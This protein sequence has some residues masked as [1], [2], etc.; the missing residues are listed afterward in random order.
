MLLDC[1]WPYPY[2]N[3][4]CDGGDVFGLYLFLHRVG[5]ATEADY[6]PYLGQVTENLLKLE[7]TIDYIVIYFYQTNEQNL[8]FNLNCVVYFFFNLTKIFK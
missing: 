6:G 4:G 8:I 5:I 3:Y 1:S 7:F 2:G